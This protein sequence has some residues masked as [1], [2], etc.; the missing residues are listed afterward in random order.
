MKET[1]KIELPP[2]P[3]QNPVGSGESGSSKI[4][5][6]CWVLLTL[7]AGI[8]LGLFFSGKIGI[9]SAD[10]APPD[11]PGNEVIESAKEEVDRLLA[12]GERAVE[13]KKWTKARSIY[14]EVQTLDPENAAAR[15]ALK[16][17]DA[18]LDGARGG[19]VVKTVPDGAWVKVPGKPKMKTPATFEQLPL[20]NHEV[21]IV[22]NGYEPVTKLV[23]IE[24][25]EV[26]ELTD[27][28]L[29]LSAGQLDVSSV[30]SGAEF[31]LHKLDEKGV[32][33]A[34]F[35][36]EGKTPAKIEEL[37]PGK[38]KVKFAM[39][40][41]QQRSESVTVAHDREASVSTVFSKGTVNVTSDPVGAEVW[42]K[43]ENSKFEMKG[44]TPFRSE[45]LPKGRYRFELRYRDWDPI[46]RTV[47]ITGEEK[48][49][50]IDIA[51]PRGMVKFTSDPEGAIVYLSNRRVGKGEQQTPFTEEFPAGEYKLTAVHPKYQN[52]VP[53]ERVITVD[54]SVDSQMLESH[55]KFEYGSVTINSEPAGA[56]VFLNDQRVGK[57]PF[58]ADVVK[59][60]GY[61]YTI[62]KDGFRSSRVSGEVEAGGSLAFN[63]SLSFDPTP[64]FSKDFTNGLG[65]EMVWIGHLKGWVGETEITRGTWKAV[66]SEKPASAKS[67]GQLGIQPEKG[68]NNSP[69]SAPRG[70]AEDKLP[71]SGVSWYE[72]SQFCEKLTINE[73]ARGT[74]PEG[75]AYQLP[76]DEQWSFFVGKQS[77]AQ[78]V[79]GKNVRREGPAPVA[80]LPPNE[81][82][83]YDVRGNVWEWCRDWYS[84]LILNRARAAGASV[85]ENWS[86]TERKVL[87]GGSWNRSADADLDIHYRLAVR[88]SD[89]ER[90]DAGLRVVLMPER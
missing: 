60:G 65:D 26:L 24:E 46:S 32:E 23:T 3:R 54:G 80:S 33:L 81:F 4:V 57:T 67:G 49:H 44:I 17:V 39:A 13:A 18:H 88:P 11:N 47:V 34:D 71:M 12:E 2:P 15:T 85:R 82:G 10:P 25:N 86:G 28:K 21:E 58:K 9:T 53:I 70:T 40:G 68:T 52:L 76:T 75:F 74:I 79:T 56:D 30:P 63:A 31:K 42:V 14:Q 20:G 69:Q 36:E 1:T 41:W 37:P 73:R 90:Y 27:L 16:L 87:R 83:L 43:P 84:P 35:I 77:L 48:T 29:V 59:P 22:L 51:W 45:D 8:T 5:V 6:V 78:A 72:A 55:F 89:S 50:E 62:A 64:K 61:S 38:Y 7:F 19:L 66:M